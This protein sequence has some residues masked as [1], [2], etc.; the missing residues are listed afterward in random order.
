MQHFSIRAQCKVAG[1]HMRAVILTAVLSCLAFPATLL[2]QHQDSHRLRRFEDRA[3]LTRESENEQSSI[4]RLPAVPEDYQAWWSGGI[5]KVLQTDVHELPISVES[6]LI[7]TLQHSSQV[8]LLKDL[9]LIRRTS[10]VEADAAFDWSA[11]IESQWNDISEPVGNTLTVGPGETRFN[12]HKLDY[13][14]GLR[15]RNFLGGQMRVAQDFGFENSNS[16]F[17][18]PPDQ[19]TAQLRL[20]YTQPLLRGAGRV[21]NTGLIVLA[22]INTGIAEQEF[23]RELQAHLLEVTRAYWGLYLA[24]GTLLQ[25]KKLYQGARR[26]LDQLEPRVELDAPR[27]Q[28]ARARAAVSARQT[29]L[30]R[31]EMTVRNAEARIRALVNDPQLTNI[32]NAEFIPQDQPIRQFVPVSM[33]ES[34]VTALQKRPEI[35]QALKEVQAAAVRMDMAD[36]ELLPVL[37]LIMD[38]YA[39]GLQGD[40]DVGQAF[41][42]QFLTGAPSYAVGLKF[43]VP[44]HNRAAKARCQRRRLEMRQ[45]TNQL[46]TTAENLMLEVEV[47]VREVQTSFREVQATH[48]SMKAADQELVYLEKRWEQLAG[49]DRT[50]SLVLEDLLAAQERLTEAEFSFLNSE[51]TYNLALMNLKRATGTLLEYEQISRGEACHDDLPEIFLHKEQQSDEQVPPPA[52]PIPAATDAQ[53][54][55]APQVP[56]WQ[57]QR[58]APPT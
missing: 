42:D 7:R 37:D 47:A 55:L 33:R 56:L 5:G 26:I 2:A 9:P 19:G 40:S 31:A 48:Q 38:A 57:P 20:S 4:R 52:E 25:K 45:V 6:L 32:Q 39:S 24:R 1:P 35:R 17:F 16:S 53:A 18:I 54:R 58:I 8:R 43:E 29:D 30:L 41:A 51:V 50:G 36:K 22:K 3:Y 34:L 15:R 12:D 49:D 28:I 21:Y 27:N 10:I 46:D 13:S 44:L 14:M 11:F 23:S